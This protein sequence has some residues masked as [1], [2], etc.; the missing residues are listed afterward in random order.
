MRRT[1]PRYPLSTELS[2]QNVSISRVILLVQ[3][4]KEGEDSLNDKLM[5]PVLEVLTGPSWKAILTAADP[6]GTCAYVGVIVVACD[7]FV[8]ASRI[9]TEASFSHR[10]YILF[11]DP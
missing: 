2:T 4:M 6:S 11:D 5:T 9:P 7:L 1:L 8:V 3:P 10:D